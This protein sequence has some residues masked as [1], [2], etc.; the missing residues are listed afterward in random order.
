MGEVV[1]LAAFRKQIAAREPHACI[2]CAEKVEATR[3]RCD[4]CQYA[5]EA[6]IKRLVDD[7]APPTSF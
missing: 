3:L 2:G 1:G 4:A 6:C 7:A 5:F